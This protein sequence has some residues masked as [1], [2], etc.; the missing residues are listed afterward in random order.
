MAI[1]RFRGRPA[2]TPPED[3]P[4]PA[5]EDLPPP[6]VDDLPYAPAAD[7]DAAAGDADDMA[8]ESIPSPPL[9]VIVTTS[10][11]CMQPDTTPS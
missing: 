7:T 2:A 3:L 6:P 1:H 9:L 10:A 8:E 4:P 5:I 11:E